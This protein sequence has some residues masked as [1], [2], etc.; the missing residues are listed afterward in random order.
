M[1]EDLLR[2]ERACLSCPQI[3]I[4]MFCASDGG[5]GYCGK[6][7]TTIAGHKGHVMAILDLGRRVL[8]HTKLGWSVEHS[9]G[10]GRWNTA[11]LVNRQRT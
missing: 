10:T 8:Q 2:A 9:C 1:G 11:L 4:C 5:S 3:A 7:A 6:C